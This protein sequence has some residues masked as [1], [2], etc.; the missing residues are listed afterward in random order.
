MSICR[1]SIKKSQKSKAKNIGVI[2]FMKTSAG[3][4]ADGIFIISALIFVVLLFKNVT[5]STE[6]IPVLSVLFMSFQM[7]CLYNGT[8]YCFLKDNMRDSEERKNNE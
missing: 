7:H 5:G 3:K 8:N 1:K 2:S 6:I 4:I